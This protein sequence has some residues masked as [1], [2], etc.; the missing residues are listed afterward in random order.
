MLRVL[1]LR[2]AYS[3]GSERVEAVKGV[4]FEAREGEVF[5]I[6]GP[7][8]AGKTTTIKSILGLVE[9]DSGEIYIDDMNVRSNR[10]K[11]LR[12]MSAV[13]EGNRNIHWRL[14]VEENLVFFGG[15]RGLG[16]K[17]LKRRMEYVVEMMGLQDMLKQLAGKLSRGYQ[18][19]LAIAIA[20]LPDTPLILL[21]EPTLGLDVESSIDIRKIIKK[22]SEIGKCVILS[23]HDMNLV[24]EV[25]DRVMIINRGK[26]VALDSKE[27]LIEMFKRRSYKMVLERSPSERLLKMLRNMADVELS[28]NGSVKLEFSLDNPSAIY[29]FFEILKEERPPIKSIEVEDMSFEDVFMRIV[30]GDE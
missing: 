23:T 3:K 2:K 18:Q 4:S 14:T 21:D 28:V 17:T 10:R 27:N 22:L 24:E 26:I 16:G 6:L 7:N 8:G 29:D 11:A 20:I 13:L 15:L 19:R 5:A 1:D 9:P 25:A 12:K 30:R